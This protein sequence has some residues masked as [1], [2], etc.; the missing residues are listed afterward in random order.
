M[1]SITRVN[2]WQ[3]KLASQKLLKLW[4]RPTARHQYESSLTYGGESYLE[5]LGYENRGYA[6]SLAQSD[7]PQRK[8]RLQVTN[9]SLGFLR[10]AEELEYEAEVLPPVKLWVRGEEI[11]MDKIWRLGAEP[12]I[13]EIERSKLDFCPF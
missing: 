5:H 13:V 10:A 8:H 4:P 7:K 1:G 6:K 2:Y 12:F 9:N 11:V 3:N